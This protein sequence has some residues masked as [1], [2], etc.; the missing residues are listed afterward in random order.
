MSGVM[1][2]VLLVA[3]IGLICAGLLVFASKVFHVEVDE[4]KVIVK[5]ALVLN[6]WN[7]QILYRFFFSIRLQI[8]AFH[9]FYLALQVLLY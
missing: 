4:T 9:R 5:L 1:T 7:Y 3:V 8:K 2:P 6:I